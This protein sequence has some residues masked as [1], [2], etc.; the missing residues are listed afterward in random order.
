[1][2]VQLDGLGDEAVA[3]PASWVMNPVVHSGRCPG[4]REA[5]FHRQFMRPPGQPLAFGEVTA[6]RG[7]RGPPR[8]RT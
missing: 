6:Q 7:E 8:E 5:R 2:F 4:I 3:G 1:M